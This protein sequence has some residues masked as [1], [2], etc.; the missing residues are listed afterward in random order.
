MKYALPILLLTLFCVSCKQED[1]N[2][3]GPTYNGFKVDGVV[4]QLDTLERDF[5]STI[6]ALRMRSTDHGGGLI[7]IRRGGIVWP[8][9]D[10]IYQFTVKHNTVDSSEVE[11]C[12]EPGGVFESYC[13]MSGGSGISTTMTL[14]ISNGKWSI[15]LPPTQIIDNSIKTLEISASE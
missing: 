9:A 4:Y 10:G 7:F 6:G 12:F 3:P 13:S 15:S 11:M 5:V 1:D 14:T 2:E 8:S